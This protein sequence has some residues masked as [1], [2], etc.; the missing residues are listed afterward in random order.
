MTSPAQSSIPTANAETAILRARA[1]LSTAKTAPWA[2]LST[3]GK[4]LVSVASTILRS[5]SGSADR[6]TRA[7]F[8]AKILAAESP[9][10]IGEG[11]RYEFLLR[12]DSL[13]EH[14]EHLVVPDGRR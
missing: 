14:L 2:P 1:C 3:V 7:L 9:S 11:N 13:L 6:R 12:A 10:V 4:E 5:Q 8:T